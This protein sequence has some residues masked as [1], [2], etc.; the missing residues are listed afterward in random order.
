MTLLLKRPGENGIKAPYKGERGLLASSGLFHIRTL[1]PV[2]LYLVTMALFSL[3]RLIIFLA[4]SDR[5]DSVSGSEILQAFVLGL[6]FD[7]VISC[8]LAATLLMVLTFAPKRL[9]MRP[10]FHRVIALYAGIATVTTLLLLVVDFYFF[11]EFGERLNQKAIQ[12]LRYDYVYLTVLDQ[13]PV[14]P[15]LLCITVLSCGFG[16]LFWRWGLV[17]GLYARPLWQTIFWPLFSLSVAVLGIRGS[18]G[19][20]PINTGPAY[21]SDSASLAQ[22]TLNGAFT[23]GQSMDSIMNKAVDLNRYHKLLPE[24]EAFALVR[25][26]LE[27]PVDHFLAD[28]DNPLRR[29]TNTGK[30]IQHY[31]VVLVILESLGWHYVGTMGGDPRLTP[32]LNALANHGLLM[33]HCFAVGGRT[34]R[35][36]SG[37]VSGFPDLPGRSITTRIEAQNNFLTL[38]SVLKSRGY[39]TMFIY[40]GEPLYDHRQAFLGSNGY[41]RFVFG[42]QFPKQTFRT[43]I[44]WSDEDLFDTAHEVFS[45]A[46]NQPFLATLLTLIF[47]RPYAIPTGRIDPVEP[48]HPYADQLDAIR[49]SDWALGKFMAKAR[50]AR[51]F[52]RTLFV[53]VGDH[54]GGFLGRSHDPINYRVPFLIYAPAILGDKGRR[55][56]DTCSQTDIAPTILSLLG[57]SYRH[58]F[59]GSNVLGRARTKAFAL[60]QPGE[61]GE[62]LAVDGEKNVLVVPP[63][64]A[65]AK[66]FKFA[67]PDRLIAQDPEG[68]KFRAHEL[69]RRAIAFLQAADLLFRREAYTP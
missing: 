17:G 53:F 31:N 41:S 59:F 14:L 15:A 2:L 27:Q 69:R 49:Y 9:L 37:I 61:D 63:F 23:L 22:L 1:P 38:G 68:A 13:Y 55:I 40:G 43:R 4:M 44:G 64:L 25:R 66:L 47:H 54:P 51:Y 36:F 33:D 8:A 20:K 34:T 57:G 42:D 26:T 39:E 62:L 50:Q 12:Y 30:S 6:R 5:F 35:G 21:F 10:G 29:I 18:L 24:D 60:V 56:S 32:N 19:N 46:G 3:Q 45:S 58:S 67:T 65:P 28:P 11:E 52:D 7:T 16:F 48:N